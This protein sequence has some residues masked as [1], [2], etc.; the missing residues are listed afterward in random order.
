MLNDIEEYT[1]K[2]NSL[3]SF[4]NSF[5]EDDL[6]K[7]GLFQ[8]YKLISASLYRFLPSIPKDEY[9]DIVKRIQILRNQS[10]TDQNFF[11]LLDK[12]NIIDNNKCLESLKTKSYIVS[13]YHTGSYRLLISLFA[14]LGIKFALVTESKFIT[15]QGDEINAVY[16]KMMRSLGVENFKE[17]EIFSAEDT[18]LLFKLRNHL[19]NGYSIIFYIDGNTGTSR[20]DIDDSK[21]MN[22]NFLADF[23]NVRKGIAFLSFLTKTPIISAICR[24]INAVENELKFELID[25][26][27]D[28]LR[29]D[30]INQTTRRLFLILEN[31][32]IEYPDQWE[33]WFYIH[34]FF[35]ISEDTPTKKKGFYVKDILNRE[36]IFNKNEF[37]LL[38]IQDNC[39]IIDYK[40]Y[41][42]I[43]IN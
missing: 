29:N 26:Q 27:F 10:I 17:I 6:L 9:F 19:N 18:Q 36:L 21:L 39:F 23:I 11:F 4:I 30:F 28:V 15:D 41:K 7:L 20:F 13:T 31:F 12:L 5:N 37:E 2:V 34:K 40:F 14:K 1:I 38:N 32:L 43:E 35:K 42:I 33:G 16:S 8:T 24:K 22:I 3:K 25:N